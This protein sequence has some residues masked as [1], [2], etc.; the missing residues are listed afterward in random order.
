MA[1][2]SYRGNI[3]IIKL[4]ITNG[5]ITNVLTNTGQNVLHIAAQGD[6]P[7]SIIYFKEKFDMNINSKDYSGSTPV[8]WACHTGSELSLNF[9]IAFGADVNAK[10][11]VGITPLHLSAISEKVRIIKKL[12]QYGADK[13]IKDNKGRTAYDIAKDRNKTT[14]LDLIADNRNTLLLLFSDF[15]IC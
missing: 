11:C 10:D 2:S 14:I 4:L 9:L 8:H 13:T 15:L 12:L 6:Q 3:E 5:A 7:E 1:Y